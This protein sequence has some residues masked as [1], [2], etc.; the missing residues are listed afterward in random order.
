MTQQITTNFSTYIEPYIGQEITVKNL[1]D[2]LAN[3]LEV[4]EELST[5][6]RPLHL[7][8]K[9]E[10]L[11]ELLC[12]PLVDEETDIDEDTIFKIH[13]TADSLLALER[14]S[15]KSE[16]NCRKLKLEFSTP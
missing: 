15:K 16:A 3:F 4:Q 12:V 9:E 10:L 2:K 7:H 13:K 14:V 1:L 11:F 5:C 6:C 8:G